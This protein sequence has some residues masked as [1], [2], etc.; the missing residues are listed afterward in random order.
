MDQDLKSYYESNLDRYL[1]IFKDLVDINSHTQNVSGIK[2]I[3]K[4]VDDLFTELGCQTQVVESESKDLGPHLVATLGKGARTIGLIA[5]FDTVYSEQEELQNNFCWREEGDRIYGPGTIDI[6]GG[7]LLIYMFL[8]ALKTVS[9]ELLNQVCFKV[10]LNSSEEIAAEDFHELCCRELGEQAKAALVFE[11]EYWHHEHHQLVVARKGI[12]AFNLVVSGK[13]AHAGSAHDKG[14]NAIRKL[15][16]IVL[17]LE[18]LT[19]YVQDL[20]INVGRISGGTVPNS[21]PAHAEIDFEVRCYDPDLL[22]STIKKIQDRIVADAQCGYAGNIKMEQF[23]FM[24]AWQEN[25]GSN[26]LLGFWQKAGIEY[27][28]NYIPS[29]RGGGS[30]G[31]RLST[32]C[33]TLDG[34]GLI[35]AHAHCAVSNPEKG[36]EQEYAI[37]SSI[38]PK[39]CVNF[40]AIL[41]LVHS[42][43]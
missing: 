6:K 25:E 31:N 3:N 34:L 4:Y 41:L 40:K 15:S 19:D 39:A 18:T 32:I 27:G 10:L 43:S 30:D 17:A 12:A 16:E 26:K 9:P 23:E 37:K 38:I 1:N 28:I 2:T 21:V 8:D 7:I 22:S 11:G 5:H 29:K 42:E 35:G 33:P 13:S 24:S 14:I 20:T 36:I